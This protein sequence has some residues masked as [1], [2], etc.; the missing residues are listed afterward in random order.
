MAVFYRDLSLDKPV[1]ENGATLANFLTGKHG[2]FESSVCLFD[3]LNRLPEDVR[4]AA[5]GLMDGEPLEAL[6]GIYRWSADRACWI[7]NQLRSALEEYA[8]I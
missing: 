6:R 4:Q 5:Y 7:Y 3:Y 8:A 2:N 1:C